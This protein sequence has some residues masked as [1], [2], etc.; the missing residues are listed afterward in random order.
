M[1]IA[2]VFQDLFR[3]VD[4]ERSL[5]MIRDG[6]AMFDVKV[7]RYTMAALAVAGLA[8]GCTAAKPTPSGA[9]HVATLQSPDSRTS[10]AADP[11]DQQPLIRVDASEEER[12]AMWAIWQQCVK[13]KGGPEFA[14]NW[15]LAFDP[16]PAA[17]AVRAACLAKEPETYEQRQKR[18]DLTA[19]RDNQRQWYECAKKQGYKVNT[20]DENGEFGLTE[21]GPE[22][23]FQSPKIEACR[24]A[25]FKD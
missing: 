7:V 19:F 13:Q 6:V 22:G 2:A 15:K 24:I 20:P 14:E 10:P 5:T 8:A 4:P 25:A 9:G 17:K 3:S 21:I 11:A 18:T 1:S 12:N 16:T 23:D